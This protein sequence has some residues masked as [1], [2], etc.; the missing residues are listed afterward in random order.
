MLRAVAISVII[1]TFLIGTYYVVAATYVKP[2][3]QDKLADALADFQPGL[4]YDKF[5]SLEENE[6][7]YLVQQMPSSIMTML[8][9]EARNHPSSVAES[10]YDIKAQTGSNELRLI[11]LTQIFGLKGYDSSGEASLMISGDKA[12]LR[13]QEFSVTSGIDQHVYLSKDGTLATGI[14][15]GRLKASAGDQY[16]DITGI[17]TEVYNIMIIYSKTFDTYYAQAKFLKT[18]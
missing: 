5:V 17:D 18:E 10:A 3:P 9:Q 4:T 16:Y 6:R 1:G 12:I 11:K 8:L 14:D 2:I 15:V 13:L 7:R